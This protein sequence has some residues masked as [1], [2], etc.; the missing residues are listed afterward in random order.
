MIIYLGFILFMILGC[1]IALSQET[2]IYAEGGLGAILLSFM[3]VGAGQTI[4][5]VFGSLGAMNAL[6]VA[7]EKLA[8][9]TETKKDDALALKFKEILNSTQKF[10]N[11][12]IAKR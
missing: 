3:P 2:A 9:I 8:S 6:S 4:A 7:I 12:F 10:L 1:D 5:L 11:F